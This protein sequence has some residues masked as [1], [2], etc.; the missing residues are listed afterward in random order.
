MKPV[1]LGVACTQPVTDT[2]R[3]SFTVTFDLVVVAL[4]ALRPTTHIAARQHAALMS[5]MKSSFSFESEQR[6]CPPYLNNGAADAANDLAVETLHQQSR[7]FTVLL[8][9]WGRSGVG[10]LC[11]GFSGGYNAVR[12]EAS[13]YYPVWA[14]LE[15]VRTS[16]KAKTTTES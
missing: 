11:W 15:A 9:Y 5:F 14:R 2:S 12:Y 16:I 8:V 3:P 1:P 6:S 7:L 4:C 13:P 10:D